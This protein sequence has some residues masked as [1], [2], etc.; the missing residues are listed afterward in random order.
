[1]DTM[2]VNN[3]DGQIDSSATETK[4][5]TKEE[6]DL[7]NKKKRSEVYSLRGYLERLFEIKLAL[8]ID[9]EFKLE[10][11]HVRYIKLTKTYIVNEYTLREYSNLTDL[12]WGLHNHGERNPNARKEWIKL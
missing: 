2:S 12:A 3:M 8:N 5:K 7:I 11:N 10:K 4:P 6:W 9:F 1:M